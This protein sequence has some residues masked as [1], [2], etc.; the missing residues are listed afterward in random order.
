MN[1]IRC[2]KIHALFPVR[3]IGFY[4]ITVYICN[5]QRLIKIF[6]E[7]KISKDIFQ[8]SIYY[9]LYEKFITNSARYIM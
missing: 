7:I 6:S 2:F 9:V 3:L 4:D 8:I 1:W 5:L